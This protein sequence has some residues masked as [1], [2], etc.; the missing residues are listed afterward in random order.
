MDCAPASGR[1]L[2]TR[3]ATERETALKCWRTMSKHLM[4]IVSPR[5]ECSPSLLQLTQYHFTLHSMASAQCSI[6]SPLDL[7][8]NREILKLNL[9]EYYCMDSLSGF[10]FLLISFSVFFCT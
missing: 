10:F 8:R 4:R 9:K 1:Y 2:K 7:P 6:C 5:L 3:T